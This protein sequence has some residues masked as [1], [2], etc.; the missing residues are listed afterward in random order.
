MSG[1]RWLAPACA[2]LALFSP[3]IVAA[4]IVEMNTPGHEASRSSGVVASVVWLVGLTTGI[5][6]SAL[7]GRWG[8]RG[9]WRLLGAIG[10]IVSLVAAVPLIF[11]LAM[12]GAPIGR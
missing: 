1:P 4:V 11:L 10:V 6:V 5:A 8:A 3:L 12:Y 9:G 7:G 2:L